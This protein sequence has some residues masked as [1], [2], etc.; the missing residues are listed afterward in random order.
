MTTSRHAS[1][2]RSPGSLGMALERRRWR[3]MQMA[4]SGLTSCWPLIS[5]MVFPWR[6]SSVWSKSQT[7]KRPATSSRIWRMVAKLSV[8]WA[9]TQWVVSQEV[10]HESAEE[11]QTQKRLAARLPM[12]TAS[13]LSLHRWWQ[14]WM[15]TLET[16]PVGRMETV[17]ACRE[18]DIRRGRPGTPTPPPPPLAKGVGIA[19]EGRRTGSATG[20]ATT[21]AGTADYVEAGT[22]VT[23]R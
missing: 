1:Q 3:L 19:L 6:S 2:R 13:K 21:A 4:G 18:R 7:C 8:R 9:N 11:G 10:N 14:R 20:T 17:C 12:E 16:P 5:W 15:T 22:V 23:R